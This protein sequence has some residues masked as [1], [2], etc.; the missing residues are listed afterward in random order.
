MIIKNA[1]M[2]KDDRMDHLM[3]LVRYIKKME[4]K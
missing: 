2:I 4:E 1:T 3:I